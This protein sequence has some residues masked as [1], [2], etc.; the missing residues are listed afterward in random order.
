MPNTNYRWRVNLDKRFAGTLNLNTEYPAD[1]DILFSD[2]II[3]TAD[4]RLGYPPYTPCKFTIWNVTEGKDVNFQF[5]DYY[6]RDS[7]LSPY[8]AYQNPDSIEAAIVWIEDD[9]PQN[10]IGVKTTWR[11]Y[12]EADAN[13]LQPVPPEKD[14]VFHLITKKPFRTGDSF[15]FTVK[16]KQYN[17]DKA[18]ADMDKIAV[19]PNPYLASASWEAKSPFRTGRGERKIYFTNLPPVCT[20]RIYTIRGY[21]VQTIEHRADIEIGQESWNLLSKDGQDIAYGVYI[22]HVDAP[23]VGQ[24]IGKFAIIK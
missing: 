10:K 15:T 9:N 7:T 6:E 19:V 21:L 1:Y 2:G 11:F 13:A 4:N 22:F 12:F 23:G 17:A 24:K 3:D 20:I 14:D 18:K 8:Y 5:V 16:G